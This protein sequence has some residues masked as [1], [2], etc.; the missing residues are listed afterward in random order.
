MSVYQ[1][2]V[3]H[4]PATLNNN[5]NNTSDDDDWDTDADYVNDISEKDQRW[6]SKLI[7]PEVLEAPMHDLR[8][9]NFARDAENLKK[10]YEAK[11]ILYG[12]ERAASNNKDL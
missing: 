10:E 2:T 1:K 5:T 8:E 9:Q 6:G 11:K 7:Q 4:A 3:T 12:G